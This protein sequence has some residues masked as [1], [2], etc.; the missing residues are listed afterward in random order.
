MKKKFIITGSGRC[1]TTY[2]AACLN[3]CGIKAGHQAIDYYQDVRLQMH[4]LD[5]DV[6]YKALGLGVDISRLDYKI[7]GIYREPV[8]TVRSLV[9]TGMIDDINMVKESPIDMACEWYK[10]CYEWIYQKADYVFDIDNI[11]LKGLFNVLGYENKYNDSLISAIPKD[12]NNRNKFKI[13][14]LE[15]IEADLKF[16]LPILYRKLKEREAH[17]F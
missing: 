10:L 8:A 16:E 17:Q 5:G 13:R 12:S 9:E 6:S 14:K 3:I 7:I 4:D 2:V 1:G 15:L 11:N